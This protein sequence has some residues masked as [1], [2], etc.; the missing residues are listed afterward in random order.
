M[1]FSGV[2]WTPTF[3]TQLDPPLRSRGPRPLVFDAGVKRAATQ[4]KTQEATGTLVSLLGALKVD[5]SDVAG[6]GLSALSPSGVAEARVFWTS[7]ARDI[8]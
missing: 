1:D 4:H 8:G 2:S 5:Y 3:G 6:V 7:V